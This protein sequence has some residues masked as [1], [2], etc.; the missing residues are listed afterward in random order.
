MAIRCPNC[1]N[2]NPD[3]Y[4]YCDECGARLDG[5]A[6]TVVSAPAGGLEG[7]SAPAG[8]IPGGADTAARDLAP[9][10]ADSGSP[11]LGAGVLPDEATAGAAGG[12]GVIRC[13]HCGTENMAGAAFCDECG[14]ALN[15]SV[16]GALPTAT[17]QPGGD[18]TGVEVPL[19]HPSDVPSATHAGS[20]PYSAPPAPVAA[21]ESTRMVETPAAP[22][23]VVSPPALSVPPAMDITI[24]PATEVAT[25]PAP[26]MPPPA[27]E[28]TIPTTPAAP[29]M[30]WEPPAPVV[31]APPLAVAPAAP[32][33]E[34]LVCANCGTELKPGSRFCRSCGT[35]VAQPQPQV[36]ANCG[37]PLEPGAR[38][39]ENCGTPVAAAASAPAAPPPAA[40]VSTPVAP[41]APTVN[42][43]PESV[44]TP[45]APVEVVGAPVEAPAVPA[46][47]MAPAA[48]AAPS[49]GPPRLELSA[50]GAIVTLPDKDDILIGREDPMSE[51]PIF[52]DIDLTPYGGEEG[53]VS[54]RHA[55]IFRQNGQYFVEDLH[56]TNYTKLDGA[57]LTPRTPLPLYN[58]ARI[59]FG[60]V[61]VFFRM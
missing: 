38:F 46:P 29:S 58:G 57:K 60:K 14:A 1:G 61:T 36:C 18:I 53:G 45:V 26:S 39:C 6:A 55:R 37:S 35:P 28:D 10:A 8:A 11:G 3:D 32:V 16:G 49:G 42:P 30:P 20:E 22:P 21:T 59:D 17:P 9:P 41:V 52:P 47:S 34:G 43:A 5:G 25:A 33:A 31:E 54:R 48:P 50:S 19:S 13:P 2:E 27:S 44:S 15:G 40:S 24:A 7:M 12:P 51:P 23:P 4:A 56:A